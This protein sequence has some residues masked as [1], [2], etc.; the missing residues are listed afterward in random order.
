MKTEDVQHQLHHVQKLLDMAPLPLELR[1]SLEAWARRLRQYLRS[2]G[3]VFNV[4]VPEPE[5]GAA[6]S[7]TSAEE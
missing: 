4:Q 2:G 7:D 3:V 5:P 6:P 1:A